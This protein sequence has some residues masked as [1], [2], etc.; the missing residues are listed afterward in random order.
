LQNSRGARELSRSIYFLVLKS[1]SPTT[2]FEFN[3]SRGKKKMRIDIK[4]F[5]INRLM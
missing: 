4:M 1:S 2:R 5:P 3:I